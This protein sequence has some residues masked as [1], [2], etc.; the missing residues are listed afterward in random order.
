M[1]KYDGGTWHEAREAVGVRGI[2]SIPQGFQ[3][4]GSNFLPLGTPLPERLSEAHRKA[5]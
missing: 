5:L 3:R 2:R 1:P 4:A